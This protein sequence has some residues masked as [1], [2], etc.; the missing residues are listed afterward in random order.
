VTKERGQVVLPDV[1]AYAYPG[2]GEYVHRVR[3]DG[4]RFRVRRPRG[5][6]CPLPQWCT[7]ES[8]LPLRRQPWY[9]FAGGWGR[10]FEG[11]HTTGPLGPSPYRGSD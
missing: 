4:Q 5:G 6:M 1:P 9:G 11:T 8:L 3:A 10:V 7:W 2:S